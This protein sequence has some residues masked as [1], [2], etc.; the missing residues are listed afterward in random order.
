MPNLL[1]LKTRHGII[2]KCGLKCYNSISS[3]C[4][5]ICQ[6][7]N[8]GRGYY[9]ALQNSI[10]LISTFQQYDPYIHLSLHSRRS[11]AKLNQTQITFQPNE[12]QAH[13]LK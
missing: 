5:C 2:S 8:H 6:G 11:L 4:T 7:S 10:N 3:R 12:S 1:T 9:Y 13:K